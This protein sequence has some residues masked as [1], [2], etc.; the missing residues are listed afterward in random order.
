MPLIAE[1]AP[2]GF[3]GLVLQGF[4]QRLKNVVRNPCRPDTY[5]HF[6]SEEW[7]ANPYPSAVKTHHLAELTPRL[8]Q[9]APPHQNNTQ[10]IMGD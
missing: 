7:P 3:K 8:R 2:E 5:T 9:L 4:P 10:Y 1:S 6:E